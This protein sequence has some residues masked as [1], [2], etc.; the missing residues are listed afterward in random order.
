M[1]RGIYLVQRDEELDLSHSGESSSSSNSSWVVQ[2]YVGN[3][4]LIDGKKFDLRLYVLVTSVDPLCIY[5]FD[6]GLARFATSKCAPNTANLIWGKAYFLRRVFSAPRIISTS[7]RC[8]VPITCYEVVLA[9]GTV[10]IRGAE[11][12]QPGH[13]AHAPDE[14]L[15]QQGVG[16]V[17]VR[18]DGPQPRLETPPHGMCTPARNTRPVSPAPRVPCPAAQPVL[19]KCSSRHELRTAAPSSGD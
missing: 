18:R 4:F 15:H 11:S 13:H 8:R 5:L 16:A 9:W 7:G 2:E 1:G 17:R 12:G 6:E 14:L 19:Q 10:Q 3:P